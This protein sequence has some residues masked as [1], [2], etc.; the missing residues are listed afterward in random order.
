MILD[1]YYWW[2]KAA[3]PEKICD[4]ILEFGKSQTIKKAWTG[5]DEKKKNDNLDFQNKKRKSKI[6]WLQENWI[7]KEINPLIHEANKN[8]G[9]NFEWS[10][11]EKCQFTRYDEGD[12]YGWHADGY[13]KGFQKK[14]R[15]DVLEG[16][17]RKLSMTVSLSDPKDYKGGD[18]QFDFRNDKDYEFAKKEYH[19]CEEIIPK[20]SVIIFPSFLWH[21]VTPVTKGTRYSLVNWSC[22]EPWR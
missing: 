12:F 7:Y 11:N 10:W 3:L 21:R 1:N 17:I 13:S 6:A 20:G 4:E 8:A 5:G 14:H 9:W 22:G 18:L 16:K 2:F 15:D 19:I